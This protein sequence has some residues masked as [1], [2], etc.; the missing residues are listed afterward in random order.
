MNQ[1]V[2]QEKFEAILQEKYPL[3]EP[4]DKW[5]QTMWHL[6]ENLVVSLIFSSKKLKFCFF[7]NSSLK[8]DKNQRWSTTIFS[9]N[10]EYGY[11]DIIN[12]KKIEGLI[13]ST[14]INYK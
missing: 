11:E 5:K 13:E 12:W 4:I 10:I 14:V 6:N 7:N 1:I 3:L 8:L 9:E 2:I